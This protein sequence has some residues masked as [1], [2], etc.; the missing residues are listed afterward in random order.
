MSYVEMANY[1][2]E[3]ADTAWKDQMNRHLTPEQQS[4]ARQAFQDHT[5]AARGLDQAYADETGQ[6]I[7]YTALGKP[8]FSPR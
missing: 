6:E 8:I 5:R 2:R 7:R 3:Q 1:H 4:K